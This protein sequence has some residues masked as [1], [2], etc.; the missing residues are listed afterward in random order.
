M[1]NSWKDFPA[2]DLSVS[3]SFRLNFDEFE[4]FNQKDLGLCDPPD[5]FPSFTIQEVK[6]QLQMPE[7]EFAAMKNKIDGKIRQFHDSVKTSAVQR[8]MDLRC[9][10]AKNLKAKDRLLRLSHVQTL[11][12]FLQH[13]IQINF[14]QDQILKQYAEKC[15]EHIQKG[16]K[17]AMLDLQSQI[18]E[19]R[20]NANAA[21][22]EEI[23]NFPKSI[24]TQATKIWYELNSASGVNTLDLTHNIGPLTDEDTN[25]EVSETMSSATY[26]I[27]LDSI[28]REINQQIEKRR[29]QAEESR[30]QASMISKKRLEVET[31]ASDAT[32]QVAQTSI[33]SEVRHMID[34]NND[35]LLRKMEQILEDRDKRLKTQSQARAAEPSDD[36]HPR[37]PPQRVSSSDEPDEGAVCSLAISGRHSK[38]SLDLSSKN[39]FRSAGNS[40]HQTKTQTLKRKFGQEQACP[41]TLGAQLK[42]KAAVSTI[43]ANQKASVSTSMASQNPLSHSGRLV[44]TIPNDDIRDERGKSD[45]NSEKSR[46]PW[47]VPSF[48]KRKGGRGPDLD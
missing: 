11:A 16:F 45:G 10:L 31:K 38:T 30:L 12:K 48:G 40:G 14:G 2:P 25:F 32:D 1:S 39:D 20:E 44:I 7:K 17:K 34:K 27:T 13:E 35:V 42:Q 47:T 22:V 15:Q 26:K 28:A 24:E 8:Y 23:E 3:A 43:M 6:N 9:Q 33:L 36:G 5:G 4:D 46:R 21:L 37:D 19:F 29:H 41:H 18:I